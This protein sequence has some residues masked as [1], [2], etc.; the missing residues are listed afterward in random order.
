MSG[1]GFRGPAKKELGGGGSNMDMPDPVKGQEMGPV[2][3]LGS[4]AREQ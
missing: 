3:E 1:K 2:H 4:C